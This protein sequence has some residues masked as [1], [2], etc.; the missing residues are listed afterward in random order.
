MKRSRARRLSSGTDSWDL[1]VV[2]AGSAGLPCAISAGQRGAQVVV[3]EKAA[4]IGGT[5]LRAGGKLSAA[6]TRRQRTR[7][8]DDS[9][10][11]HFEDVMKLTQGS[12][13]PDLVRVAV[14]EAPHTVDWLDDLGFPFDPLTPMVASSHEAY[15]VPR[16][17]WGP[18]P[19]TRPYLARTI[20]ETIRPLWDSLVAAGTITPLLRHRLVGIVQDDRA[21]TGV[22]VRSAGGD[23]VVLSAPSVVLTSG[24]YA[25]NPDL[26]AE[27]TPGGPRPVSVAHETSTGDGLLAALEVGARL[28]NTEAYHPGCGAVEGIPGSLRAEP[29]FIKLAAMVRAPREIHVNAHGERFRS[30]DEPS[31][32]SLGPAV[33]RQPRQRM[34][35]IFDDIALGTG[36]SV[37]MTW[38]AQEIR[39]RARDGAGIRTSDTLDGLAVLAGI[40]PGGLNATVAEWNHAVR[41]GYD[42][43]GRTSPQHPVASPPFYAIEMQLCVGH[44]PGGL[45]VDADLRVLDQGG[46]PIPN[47]YAAGE[48]LGSVATMGNTSVGGMLVTPALS[49]G[50][51]LGRRLAPRTAALEA[52]PR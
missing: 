30:E 39:R 42:R 10:E 5:L 13:D 49:F 41:T 43:V 16:V 2:G 23:E 6:G 20:L 11:R 48:I 34:W 4:Q 27:L 15:S 29:E 17:Y 47:L 46:S 19:V 26:F 33:M 45:A 28:R 9:P 8:I 12:A 7:G 38:D 25:S 21:V 35:L 24:G 50:R 31:S 40:D 3:V 44:S 18:G 22:R 52:A 1:I 51:I 14:Q 37:H 32:D 36:D